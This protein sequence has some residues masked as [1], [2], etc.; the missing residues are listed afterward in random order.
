[1]IH[2]II[3]SHYFHPSLTSSLLP[4]PGLPLPLHQP[5]RIRSSLLPSVKR[6]IVGIRVD[7]TRGHFRVPPSSPQQE[8]VTVPIQHVAHLSSDPSNTNIFKYAAKAGSYDALSV[9][10]ISQFFKW[11]FST[12]KDNCNRVAA[13][14]LKSPVSPT[15]VRRVKL[16]I[17]FTPI[18]V[19]RILPTKNATIKT[20]SN[21]VI[22]P[23]PLIY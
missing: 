11:H 7:Q 21:R 15:Q 14:I 13:D 17:F 16:G 23:E 19:Q 6:R 1:M 20:T 4:T 8:M 22:F 9:Y 5:P 2:E 18:V 12:T 10:Q 3:C